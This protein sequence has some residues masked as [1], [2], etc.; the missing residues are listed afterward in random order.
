[1]DEMRQ[2]ICITCG[3]NRGAGE[4]RIYFDI[5]KFQNYSYQKCLVCYMDRVKFHN[6]QFK[7]VSTVW[8]YNGY[9]NNL[10]SISVKNSMIIYLFMFCPVSKYITKGPHKLQGL[11]QY[12]NE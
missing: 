9:L 10:S 1:M 8:G 5:V 11:I 4:R 6:K 2:T 3:G 7:S 12:Q